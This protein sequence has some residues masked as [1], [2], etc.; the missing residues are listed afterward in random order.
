MTKL[1]VFEYQSISHQ[2]RYAKPGFEP[3][4]FEAFE[5][6]FNENERTPYFELISKGVRFK[7]HVGVIQVGDL[8]VE[9]LP[10]A[11][12][13]NAK[14]SANQWQGILLEML[15]TCRLLTATKSSDASLKL[16]ANSILKLYFELY[17]VELENLIHKGLIKKYR[18]HQSQQKALKGALVFSEQI[19]RNLVHKERF[20]VR[21]TQ[22][23]K[24]HLV[25]Q[26][27]H[28]AFWSFKPLTMKA[29]LPIA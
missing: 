5:R 19:K 9:V 12:K 8:V 18:P 26:V 23:D 1:Q 21:H 17:L 22:Y 24:K 25:H 10:K 3:R 2:G 6:Y 4:H 27:L 20:Y 11:D 13:Q 16:K 7:S 29:P 14:S 28:E 15:K